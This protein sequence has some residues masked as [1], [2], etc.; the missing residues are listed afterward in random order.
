[1]TKRKVNFRADAYFRSVVQY[2]SGIWENVKCIYLNV[3]VE[4]D[5]AWL[6]IVGDAGMARFRFR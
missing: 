1:L 2:L 6:I 5:A 4:V 3:K